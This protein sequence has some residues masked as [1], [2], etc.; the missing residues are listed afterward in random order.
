MVFLELGQV[1]LTSKVIKLTKLDIFDN[2]SSGIVVWAIEMCKSS[3]VKIV[4]E[5]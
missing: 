4:D 3:R 2:K 5:K 1:A